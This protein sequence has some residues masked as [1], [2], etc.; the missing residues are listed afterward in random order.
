M[1]YTDKKLEK[2]RSIVMREALVKK[3]AIEQE[4]TGY[5]QKALQEQENELYEKAYF[6]IQEER[7]KL[8][9]K[10]ADQISRAMMEKKRSFFEERERIVD[11]VF[12]AVQKKLANYMQTEDYTQFLVGQIQAS[13]KESGDGEKTIVINQSDERLLPVLKSKISAEFT[14]SPQDIIGGCVIKNHTAHT[15]LDNSL[16]EKLIFEKQAFIE[17]SG[18]GIQK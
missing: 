9:K 1:E 3:E 18:L 8:L 13:L 11:E 5:K 16:K 14:I 7:R 12:A 15:I 4:V 2:F 17:R 10:T 6:Y